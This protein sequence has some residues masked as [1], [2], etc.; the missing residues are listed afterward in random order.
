[1]TDP[2][3][4]AV[5]ADLTDIR[6][7]DDLFRHVNGHWL[8]NHEI[9]ADRGSDGSFYELR[10]LS[11]DRVK[12][13]LDELVEG[14][15]SGDAK[16]IADYF[17]S[18]MNTEVLNAAG[19]E[20]LRADLDLV[21][22]AG[23]K[24]E[25][26]TVVGQLLRTG[27]TVPFAVGVSPDRSDPNRYALLV[28]QS[29]LSLPD[30]AYY[31]EP[32]HAETLEAFAAFVPEFFA[33]SGI[34]DDPAAAA[35]NVLAVEKAL[36]GEHWDVVTM[37]DTSKTHN[38]TPWADFVASA[39]G[40]NWDL[41]MAGAGVGPDAHA[42]PHLY[43]PEPLAGIAKVW[44][45]TDIEVLK[46]Y[47]RWQI[48]A[49]RSP[50]LT[51]A[52]DRKRFD[53]F[54]TKLTG[55]TEQRVRWRRA[56]GLVDEV[57]GNAL[58]K[59]YVAKHF[60]PE[61]KQKMQELVA[62]LLEAYRQSILNLDWMTEATKENALKKLSTF[63]PKTGYPDT[64]RDYTELQIGTDLVDNVRAANAFEFD[65]D[66]AKMGK[67]VDR[68]EW[69]MPPQ[70]VNAYYNPVWNEIA[71]PAAILQP[72][73]FEMGVDDA[74][75]YGAIGAVIGHEIGHGFD[76]MGSRYDHEGKLNNWWTD[77]DRTEFE[78]RT[79]ALI[80]QYNAYQPAQL[81]GTEHRV[82]GALT[83]GENIGDLGGLGIAIKAYEIALA[84]DGKTLEEAPVIDGMTGLQ[85]V[86]YSFARIWKGKGRDE[87]VTTL[88]SI[89]PHS[90][91]EFRCNGV[92][93]NLDSFAAAFDLAEGDDLYLAPED[94]VRIWS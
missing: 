19:T 53:F 52:L 36:A 75:N 74:W 70:M 79:T 30:E 34:V 32:Q 65:R 31:R 89:D 64:W 62:D 67:P 94:R 92:V 73:F 72:P 78:R 22:G 54:G 37:R 16:K 43:T 6:P 88:L 13:I 55:A 5:K 18:Y 7:Q 77:E 3:V 66:V 29:G 93:K 8:E 1:M 87:T 60:P 80:E 21:D 35:S 49:G 2:I 17:Q 81:A 86:F 57:L 58:G 28:A 50:Y 11:E 69:Y 83:I 47:L 10:D 4:N 23:D 27:I 85:R 14:A 15:P 24:D 59:L 44:A 38:P 48:L 76:D 63:L 25:L 20:P 41:A 90:P 46:D 56:I 12:D 45:T 51:E 68:S 26:A 91:A 9:P 33:L 42:E 84:R 82:N 71:F 61:Y 40:L 39:P